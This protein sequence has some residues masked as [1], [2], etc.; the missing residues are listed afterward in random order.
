MEFKCVIHM[1]LFKYV[2]YILKC[3]LCIHAVKLLGIKFV[4]LCRMQTL[5]IY[6]LVYLVQCSM[7]TQS[8]VIVT[9]CDCIEHLVTTCQFPN[10][11]Y[12]CRQIRGG[13]LLVS[14]LRQQLNNHQKYGIVKV[15]FFFAK[16]NKKS[17]VQKRQFFLFFVC[18]I[19]ERNMNCGAVS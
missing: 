14:Q 18:R 9:L 19:E 5:N 11:I 12:A 10:S 1:I 6:I 16:N 4:F 7:K 8:A 13:T 17:A 2:R 15:Q 3:N